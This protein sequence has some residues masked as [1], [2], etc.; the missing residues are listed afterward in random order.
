MRNE[1]GVCLV[2]GGAGARIGH[3]V[4]TM[5]AARGL[6]VVIGDTDGGATQQ[7]ATRLRASGHRADAVDLDVCDPDSIERALSEIR[8]RIGTVRSLVNSAG[9]GLELPAADVSTPQFDRIMAVNVRGSWLCA[10][11]V[12]PGMIDAG[13]GSIVNIGSVHKAGASQGYSAYAASKAALVGL[14]RGI[15]CDY[16]R[17][18][19]RCNIVHPGA[20]VS[21]EQLAE[22]YRTG[23]TPSHRRFLAERQMMPRP[24]TPA[25][26]GKVVGFLLSDDAL[27]MTGSEVWA[28]AGTSAML[29]D[30]RSPE[31]SMEAGAAAT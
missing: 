9:T 25:D 3:G 12:L 19:V 2:T 26:I 5:V 13:G 8:G 31:W 11:A 16:G 29:F 17:Q 4:S 27:S 1:E 10:R 20:V 30:H 24:V 28:D 15:A 14:T 23:A 6:H 18:F 21:P 7:L 22:D